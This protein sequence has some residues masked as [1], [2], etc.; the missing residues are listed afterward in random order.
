MPWYFD[1]CLLWLT[2]IIELPAADS[3]LALTT[4]NSLRLLETV[5]DCS[6]YTD[7]KEL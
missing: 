2:R 7:W 5:P 6:Q 3:A 1:V 4:M